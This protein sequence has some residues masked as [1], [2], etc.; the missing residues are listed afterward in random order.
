MTTLQTADK[1]LKDYY[2]GVL[3]EQMNK[4]M[5][6]FYSMIDKTSEYVYGK[7]VKKIF[8]TGHIPR[9]FTNRLC[10]LVQPKQSP[11]LEA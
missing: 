11:E 6:V 4:G 3:Q 5:G 8:S 2:L 9:R 1:V 7:D 10:I